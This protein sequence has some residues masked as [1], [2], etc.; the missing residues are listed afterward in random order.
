MASER[1]RTDF[2]ES[3]AK[4]LDAKLAPVHQR[5][6]AVELSLKRPPGITQG[7]EWAVR[8]AGEI[9]Y[10]GVAIGLAGACAVLVATWLLHLKSCAEGALLGAGPV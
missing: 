1:R 7:L 3:L 5:L 8:D 9:L 2:H 6:E 4:M 10:E